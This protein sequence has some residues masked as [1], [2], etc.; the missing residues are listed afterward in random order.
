MTAASTVAGDIGTGPPVFGVFHRQDKASPWRRVRICRT[1]S[2][3]RSM[4]GVNRYDWDE[5]LW[6]YGRADV[7]HGDGSLCIC[8]RCGKKFEVAFS[9]FNES[10]RV[11][12]DDCIERRKARRRVGRRRKCPICGVVF[13]AK[14]S[15]GVYCMSACRQMAYRR[16]CGVTGKKRPTGRTKSSRNGHPAGSPPCVTDEKGATGRQKSSRNATAEVKP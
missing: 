5:D 6:K 13:E 8:R 15:D 3:A 9:L 11:N 14:R 4:C 10:E 12:C 7:E 16:R 2:E 1:A